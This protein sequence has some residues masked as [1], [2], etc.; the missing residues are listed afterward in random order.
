MTNKSSKNT[1]IQLDVP[2]FNK[3]PQGSMLCSVEATKM[4]LEYWNDPITYDQLVDELSLWITKAESHIQGAAIFLSRRGYR[5]HFQHHDPGVITTSIDGITE[6]DRANLVQETSKAEQYSQ[7]RDKKINL[8]IEVID[9][10]AEYSTA[11]PTLSDIDR[12]LEAGIPVLV[13]VSMRI[14]ASNPNNKANH[15]ITIAG[16]NGSDYTINDPA[17]K[18]GDPMP[19]EMDENRLL[20]AW[21]QAGAYMLWCSKK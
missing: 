18:D 8:D 1:N 11:I 17:I 6:K 5:V 13:I 20:M 19:Y 3:A 16:K 10:G 12:N 9:A 2:V 21:Y 14:W 15:S 4:L 7:F